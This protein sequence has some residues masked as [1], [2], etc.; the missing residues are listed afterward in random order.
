[1]QGKAHTAITLFQRKTQV[2]SVHSGIQQGFAFNEINREQS[3]NCDPSG[4]VVK[5]RVQHAAVTS[6][7][8]AEC[9]IFTNTAALSGELLDWKCMFRDSESAEHAG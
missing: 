6:H 7:Y 2:V 3:T 9:K 8:V 5:P 4:Q 1:M